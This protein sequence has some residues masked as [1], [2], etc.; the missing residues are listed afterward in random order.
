MNS[1]SA[2][3]LRALSV[4]PPGVG[5]CVWIDR[6]LSDLRSLHQAR[7]SGY[8]ATAVMQADRVGLPRRYLAQL[9][10]QLRCP[11]RCTHQPDAQ[12][13]NRWRWVVLHKGEWELTAWPDNNRLVI[14]VSDCTSATRLVELHRTVGKCIMQTHAPEAIGLYTCGGR[15]PTDVGDQQRKRL[16]LGARRLC[17][18]GPKG[19]LFDAEIALTDATVLASL[20]R[21]D[22]HVTVWDISDEYADEV[23]SNATARVHVESAAHAARSGAHQPVCMAEERSKRKREGGTVPQRWAGRGRKCCE[24]PACDNP[25][26][27]RY[28]CRDCKFERNACNGW[29]H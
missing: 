16:N 20:L 27:P 22:A 8:H 23:L 5:H 15:H 21:P 19:A 3:L 10:Q 7:A 13:C 17:R 25:K 1:L 29:Y 14:A 2:R 28:F 6:G 9:K 24:A 18:Q 12:G 11:A 26:R 4:L